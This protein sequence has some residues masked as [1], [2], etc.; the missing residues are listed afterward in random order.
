MSIQGSQTTSIH[1]RLLAESYCWFIVMG[2][3]FDHISP[4]FLP[5]Q[6]SQAGSLFPRTA[7]RPLA[8]QARVWLR[9]ICDSMGRESRNGY[10]NAKS[11]SYN[12]QSL[13]VGC[14][15]GKMNQH[16]CCQ[17]P[18]VSTW[19][20]AGSTLPVI[21]TLPHHFA[22]SAGL[23]RNSQHSGSQ[24]SE[25]HFRATWMLQDAAVVANC[26]TYNRNQTVRELGKG[27]FFRG[28]CRGA[29]I[30]SMS[31]SFRTAFQTIYDLA[32]IHPTGDCRRNANQ[33]SD[34]P[35]H[36]LSVQC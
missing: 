16:Y 14:S 20:P 27:L 30:D 33:I 1:C 6:H 10:P 9:R 21:G 23:A 2:K 15:P 8:G 19:P 17:S 22:E 25:S 36:A 18:G 3:L 26:N 29:G 5:Q 7:D 11:A 32:G 4:Q 24:A 34:N 28:R 13:D 35:R 12:P 31:E